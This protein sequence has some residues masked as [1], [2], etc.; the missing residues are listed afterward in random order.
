MTK[1]EFLEKVKSMLGEDF[2]NFIMNRAEKVVK[3]GAINFEDYESDSYLLPKIF[4]SAI[5]EEIKFQYAP[6]DPKSIR[7]RNNIANF[8]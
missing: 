6:H 2:E 1:E 5:G 8:L 7:V 3:S 4:M